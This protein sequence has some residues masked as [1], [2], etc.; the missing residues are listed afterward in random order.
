ME[1]LP[2]LVSKNS[3][4]FYIPHRHINFFLTSAP[5]GHL[6]KQT[7]FDKPMMKRSTVGKAFQ[8]AVDGGNTAGGTGGNGLLRGMRTVPGGPSSYTG[9]PPVIRGAQT[10]AVCGI[11]RACRARQ[12][13]WY[14]RGYKPLSQ[15]HDCSWDKGFFCFLPREP[16]LKRRDVP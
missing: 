2:T 10:R 16:D 6:I 7:E 14:R 15:K 1:A 9:T 12:S 3:I 4:R 11:E 13:G 5:V 8:R